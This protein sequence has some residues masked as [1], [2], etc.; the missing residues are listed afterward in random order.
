M[1]AYHRHPEFAITLADLLPGPPPR[2]VVEFLVVLAA[3]VAWTLVL[4]RMRGNW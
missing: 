2:K 3:A 1:S 4:Y